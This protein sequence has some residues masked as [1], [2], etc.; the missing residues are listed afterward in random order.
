[1]E[2]NIKMIVEEFNHRLDAL[3]TDVSSWCEEVGLQTSVEE[4]INTEE[5]SGSYETKKLHIIKATKKIA[6][7]NPMGIWV[8]GADGR[9]DLETDAGKEILVYWREGGCNFRSE[10]SIDDKVIDN[11]SKKL[12]ADTTEGWHWMDDRILGKTPLLDKEI[13]FKVLDWNL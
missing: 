10:I 1:M 5:R 2:A 3:Y 9:V 11:S 6:T 4:K 13:F 12:F 7:L 8:I